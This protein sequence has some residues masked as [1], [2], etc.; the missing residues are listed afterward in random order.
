VARPEL[1]AHRGASRERPENTLPAFLRAIELGAAAVELDVH[2]TRDH[3]VVV[4]HDPVPRA[5]TAEAWLANRPIASLSLKE[6]KEFWVEPGVR[7]PTLASVLR[8]TRERAFVYIEVKGRGIERPVVETIRAA[9]AAERCAV[10]SFDHRAVRL[11]R[12]LAPELRTGILLGSYLV[13][14]AGA[15]RAARASDYWIWWE[16]ADA[17]LAEAVHAAGGRVVAWTVNDR[18]AAES[19]ARAGVD[20]V[21]TDDVPLIRDALEAVPA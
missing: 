17:A 18:V 2:G 12:D 6:L 8:A 15:L 7:I 10:H 20:G 1:I 13:D 5:S 9:R 3:V 19:L 11:V 16:F 4:H 21:C 14:P